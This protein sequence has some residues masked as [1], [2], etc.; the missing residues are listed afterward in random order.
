MKG[1]WAWD[2]LNT[3]Q[4]L[5][6]SIFE[7]LRSEIFKAD[8]Q[9]WIKDSNTKLPVHR[10]T[11]KVLSRWI[12]SVL[13]NQNIN[14]PKSEQEQ[15]PEQKVS[16]PQHW[17]LR[18]LMDLFMFTMFWQKAILRFKCNKEDNDKRIHPIWLS[19]RYDNYWSTRQ[20]SNN[21]RRNIK[22]FAGMS[23]YISLKIKKR[24]YEHHMIEAHKY[25]IAWISND[26][27]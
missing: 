24:H 13:W 22:P 5:R 14:F 3:V 2:T 27:F 12:L 18:M 17:I 10:K 25:L 6:R 20:T 4:V 1:P 19:C 7:S 9:S 15:E 8:S 26:I 23:P 21:E 11:S 16:V